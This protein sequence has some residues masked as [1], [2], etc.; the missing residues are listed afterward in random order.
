MSLAG[1]IVTLVTAVGCR[2]SMW[3]HN[4]LTN[5]SKN[6][7]LLLWWVSELYDMNSSRGNTSID[8]ILVLQIN[9]KHNFCQ[10]LYY[11]YLLITFLLYI[12][13]GLS[14]SSFNI[15]CRIARRTYKKMYTANSSWLLLQIDPVRT[16]SAGKVNLG[17]F[18][19]Y[20]K[21]SW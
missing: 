20:P 21:V 9:G 3:A 16:I 5:S 12:Y 17:A 13:L 1:I 15:A 18:R 4:S 11:I 6:L 8:L 7:L 2:V 19:T 14:Q 10:N